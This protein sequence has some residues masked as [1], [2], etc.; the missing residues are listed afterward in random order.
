MHPIGITFSASKNPKFTWTDSF[1]SVKNDEL[2]G[3]IVECRSAL[4]SLEAELSGRKSPQVD[5]NLVVYYEKLQ[6]KAREIDRFGELSSKERLPLDEARLVIEELKDRKVDVSQT[7]KDQIPRD[8]IR[9][10]QTRREDMIYRQFLWLILRVAGPAYVLLI[11]CSLGR[12]KVHRLNSSQSARLI[13][14]VAQHRDS[15][16][17]TVLE[18]EA[19]EVGFCQ[20]S[21]SLSLTLLH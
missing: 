9:K 3:L 5:E 16:F 7:Q 12:R 15:L 17:C 6:E 2:E 18:N 20:S 19:K 14:Y 21:M 4:H 8:Q 10:D 13:K 11:I 1:E